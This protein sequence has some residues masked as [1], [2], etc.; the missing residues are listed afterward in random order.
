MQR[1]GSVATPGLGDVEK[2]HIFPCSFCHR[3]LVTLGVGDNSQQNL[4]GAKV[5]T[6][7]LGFASTTKCLQSALS[8]CRHQT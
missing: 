4:M 1:H 6:E 8:V 7:L 3:C 2:V 5:G